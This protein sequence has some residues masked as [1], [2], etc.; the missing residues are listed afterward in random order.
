MPRTTRRRFLE[1][2]MIATATAVA[3]ASV[4]RLEAREAK[5][6]PANDTI[7]HAVIGCRIRGRVHADQFARQEGVEVA[8]VCDPDRRLA[9]ELAAAV[10]SQQGRR[11]KAVQDLRVVFDDPAVDTV[12]IATPNH[13]HALAAIWAMQAGKH[14]YVEKPVSHNVSEGRRIVQ[15]AE[16]TGRLCQA[17]TQNRS[18]G[19][20]VAA[21][22]YIRAGKFGDVTL[23]RTI[24]YGRRGS[25][26][27]RGTYEVPEQV[28]YNLYLGPA[29]ASRSRART[30]TTTGTGTGTPATASW[31]TT[32]STT[33]TSAAG[34]WG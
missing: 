7:R 6:A 23:A 3:A 21:A 26:G 12:S 33:W 10:E 11:P 28:D 29:P 9:D 31:G 34:S 18:R 15:V 13:W 14:V 30:S 25:I 4:P 27:P 5:R 17:G 19:D 2:S 16:K 20:L 22:E 1:E 32:T 24:I 8:Y